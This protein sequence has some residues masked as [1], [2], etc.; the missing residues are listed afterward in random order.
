MGPEG[1]EG[2]GEGVVDGGREVS[3]LSISE[4]LAD[5]EDGTDCVAL[6]YSGGCL[7]LLSG[8]SSS[9]TTCS[10]T[11]PPSSNMTL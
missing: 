7:V 4:S 3:I 11:G 2:L 1:P 10:E 9:I 6:T 5:G 8:V